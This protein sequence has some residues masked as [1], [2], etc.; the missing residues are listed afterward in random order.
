MFFFF[1]FSLFLHDSKTKKTESCDPRIRMAAGSGMKNIH[2]LIPI[3]GSGEAAS[4]EEITQQSVWEEEPAY[5][6]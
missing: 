5:V 4:V 2:A 6:R 1:F 3:V